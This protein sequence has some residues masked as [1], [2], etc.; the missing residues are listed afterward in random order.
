MT[1]YLDTLLLITLLT[2]EP[3]SQGIQEWLASQ[4]PERFAVSWWITAE[5][6]SALSVESTNRQIEPAEQSSALADFS[7][8]WD[9]SLTVLPIT[10]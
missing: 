4:P 9:A 1:L 5:F 8:M 3:A 10:G 7:R 2:N 6:S